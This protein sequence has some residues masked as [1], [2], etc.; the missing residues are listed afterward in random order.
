MSTRPARLR[1]TPRSSDDRVRAFV[2]SGLAEGRLA[3]GT[4][5]PTERALAARFGTSRSAVRRALV[6]LEVEGRIVRHVGRGTFVAAGATRDGD[7]GRPVVGPDASPAEV[8]DARLALEPHL[9]DLVVTNATAADI[10]TL[11][12]RLAEGR[13]ARSIEAFERADG[14]LHLAIVRATHNRLLESAIEGIDRARQNATWGK[15]KR[16]TLTPERRASYQAEHEAIV[17][18]LSERDA[19]LARTRIVEHLLHVRRN[20]LGY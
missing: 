5:L 14:M 3:A 9:A 1:T 18:A 2:L 16:D 8:M 12:A 19:R 20:L 17:A 13:A 11:E 6:V 15:L 4:R 7:A 10:R